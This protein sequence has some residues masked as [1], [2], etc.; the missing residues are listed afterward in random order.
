[1]RI[2]TR[3]LVSTAALFAS[4]AL[5]VGI[6]LP[7]HALTSTQRCGFVTQINVRGSNAPA[8]TG[9]T[10]NGR[11]YASGGSD[12]TLDVLINIENSDPYFPVYQ[13][14]LLYPAVIIDWSNPLASNYISSVQTGINNLVGEL[15]S[16]A[17]VCPAT[18]ILL[19]GYSQGADVIDQAIGLAHGSAFTVPALYSG[20]AHNLT[21]VMLFGDPGYRP[22]ER[23]DAAGNGNGSGI[24]AR[25][26]GQ[27]NNRDHLGP[28]LFGNL[29]N[30]TTV[31]S[32]CFAGDIFCQSNPGGAAVHASYRTSTA[33]QRAWSFASN[34]MIDNG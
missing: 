32:Y 17:L 30:K 27:F 34:W 5:V 31:Q 1:M 7:A 33:P 15:N 9:S 18:N 23:W 3:A 24:F 29:I 12:S 8:G 22:A 28:D 4:L 21:A 19:A 11:T 2:R 16:L 10:N 6:A 13:E 20:V 26:A 25:P 14:N